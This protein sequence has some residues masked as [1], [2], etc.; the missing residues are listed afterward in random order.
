MPSI[1]ETIAFIRKAHDGQVDKAGMPYW[2]HPVSVMQRLGPDA[3]DD[4]KHAALLHDVVEDTTYTLTDLLNMG[5][6]EA[7]VEAVRLLTKP[8]I[9]VPYLDWVRGLAASGNMIAIRVKIADN[10]DN[11]DPARI[12]LLPPEKRGMT[13]K[14]ARSLEILRGALV[15]RDTPRD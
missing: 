15:G 14:Y 6:S 3:S 13:D 10:E 12:A 4:E 1:E 7:A 11:S 5:Y 8:E 2:K 9:K